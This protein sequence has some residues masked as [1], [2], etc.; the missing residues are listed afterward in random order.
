M[1]TTRHQ[2]VYNGTQ[3]LYRDRWQWD[4]VRWGTHCV[5][6]YP[7]NCPM[8]VFVRNGIVWREEQAATFD[9]LEQGVPDLNPLGC[10]KGAAWS[11]M[12]HGPDRPLD[13]LTRAGARG[14]GPRTPLARGGPCPASEQPALFVEGV[15]A[16][17]RHAR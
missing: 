10:Q 17:V 1:T 5:D 9:T 6:C 3:D 2:P 13:P 14:G 8:R 4:S 16:A 12:P 7:G 11:Q 15:R